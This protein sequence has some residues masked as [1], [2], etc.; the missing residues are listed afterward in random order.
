MTIDRY[1]LGNY[2]PEKEGWMVYLETTNELYEDSSDALLFKESDH[3]YHTFGDL[4]E[5]WEHACKIDDVFIIVMIMNNEFGMT[6]YVPEDI[7]DKKLH[8]HLENRI[9]FSQTLEE[10]MIA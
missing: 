6:Y 1:R 7:C 10:Y 4:G 9:E 3:I 8:N 2:N 5:G